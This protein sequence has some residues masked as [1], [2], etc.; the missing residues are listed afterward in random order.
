MTHYAKQGLMAVVAKQRRLLPND[1]IF[2]K[3]KTKEEGLMI[4][5]GK[6]C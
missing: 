2:R 4:V 6:S 5:Y 3:H 1:V